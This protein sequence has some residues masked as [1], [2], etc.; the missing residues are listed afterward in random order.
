MN[1]SILI[2]VYMI[3]VFTHASDH[4]LVALLNFKATL[5][6]L[7]LSQ[8]GAWPRKHFWSRQRPCWGPVKRRRKVHQPGLGPGSL[9]WQASILPLNH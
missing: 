6:R 9:A 4:Q 7:S 2:Q 1:T 8:Q 3:A 5:H